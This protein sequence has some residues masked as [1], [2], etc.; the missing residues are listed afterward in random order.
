VFGDNEKQNVTASKSLWPE[1]HVESSLLSGDVRAACHARH[2]IRH[3]KVRIYRTLMH[4]QYGMVCWRSF[5][6]RCDL[7]TAC[8]CPRLALHSNSVTR[9]YRDGSAMVQDDTANLIP[10]S[11]RFYILTS[12]PGR[13]KRFYLLTTKFCRYSDCLRAGRPRNQSSSPGRVRN[14]HFSGS[15]TLPAQVLSPG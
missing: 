6:N 11:G 13:C 4:G 5:T 3:S 12:T 8:I 15:G 10:N 2:G 1:A 9:L 7:H 14:F